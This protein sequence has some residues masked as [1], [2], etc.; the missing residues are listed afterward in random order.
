MRRYTDGIQITL[1][2]IGKRKYKTGGQHPE[3]IRETAGGIGP[4][5]GNGIHCASQK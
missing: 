5:L 1:Q 2:T 4:G 3:S